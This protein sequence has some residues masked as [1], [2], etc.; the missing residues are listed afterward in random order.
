MSD[1][2]VVKHLRLHNILRH[3]H[4]VRVILSGGC[5][6]GNFRGGSF[7]RGLFLTTGDISLKKSLYGI[8]DYNYVIPRRHEDSWQGNFHLHYRQR[9]LAR[10]RW[11]WHHMGVRGRNLWR[12]EIRRVGY[13]KLRQNWGRIRCRKQHGFRHLERLELDLLR[14]ERI[15]WLVVM[16]HRWRRKVAR[17]NCRLSSREKCVNRLFRNRE[18]YGVFIKSKKF[19]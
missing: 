10:N 11:E 18:G 4:T 16:G 15:R 14:L 3:I 19:Y 1:G 9:H 7:S 17:R 6:R 8:L 13:R 2:L 5:F 12:L